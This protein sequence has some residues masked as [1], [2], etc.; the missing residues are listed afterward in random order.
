MDFPETISDLSESRNTVTGK[1]GGK[2]PKNRV[3][4]VPFISPLII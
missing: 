2:D 3:L 1:Y 4:S